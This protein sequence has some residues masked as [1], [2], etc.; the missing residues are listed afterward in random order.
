MTSHIINIVRD[1]LTADAQTVPSIRRKTQLQPQT[2]VDALVLLR[3][4]GEAVST[5]AEVDGRIM[6]VWRTSDV[7]LLQRA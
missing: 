1:A 5:E 2:I 7:G 4:N 3:G 6:T